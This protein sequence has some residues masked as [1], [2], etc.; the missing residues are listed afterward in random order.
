MKRTLTLRRETLTELGTDL[1]AVV[2]GNT[3]GPQPTPPVYAP[4]TLV[5]EECF[6]ISV[7]LNCGDITASPRCA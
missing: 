3:G 7:Y 5:L 1:L 2:G 6:A 4:R